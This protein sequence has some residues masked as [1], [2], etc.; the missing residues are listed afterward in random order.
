MALLGQAEAQLPQPWQAAGSMKMTPSFLSSFGTP[1]GQVRRQVR[2]II[3]LFL[4]TLAT[5]PP[6]F[7]VAFDKIVHA[8]ETAPF[9]WAI[10]SSANLGPCAS[11]H[12]KIPETGKSSG[13][14]FK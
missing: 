9:A 4:F 5:A 2:H 3:H 7:L 8:L 13:R 14:S 12:K 10:D 6:T 11:P 1:K